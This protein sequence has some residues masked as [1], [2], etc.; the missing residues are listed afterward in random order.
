MK[1]ADLTRRWTVLALLITLGIV[2]YVVEFLF[3]PPLPVPGAKLGLANL[4]TLLIIALYSWRECLLNV[5]IRTVAGSLL[6][7]TFLTPAFF[8]SLTGG[9]VSALVMLW[10]FSIWYGRLSLVGVSVTG[11]AAHNLIQLILAITLMKTWVFLFYLP[12]L[13]LA[14]IPTGLFNGLLGNYLLSRLES[15]RILL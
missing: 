2:L 11:A 4:V 12:F 14:A 3:L 1:G 8:F 5:I 15:L 9:I 7:G 6:T 13:L 10:L